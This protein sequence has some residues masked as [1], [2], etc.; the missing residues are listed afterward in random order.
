VLTFGETGVHRVFPV[1][2]VCELDI[3]DDAIA[4]GVAVVKKLRQLLVVEWYVKLATGLVQV[5]L[6]DQPFLIL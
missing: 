3:I 5:F 2:E 4:V 6:R 1:E